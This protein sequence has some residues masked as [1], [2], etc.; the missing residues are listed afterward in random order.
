M[1]PTA[2]KGHQNTRTTTPQLNKTEQTNR[3]PT[4]TVY[5]ASA[6]HKLSSNR[7]MSDWANNG[8]F[9]LSE[10]KTFCYNGCFRVTRVFQPVAVGKQFLVLYKQSPRTEPLLPPR[11]LPH[12]VHLV[13]HSPKN[14]A[15][16]AFVGRASK[17]RLKLRFYYDATKKLGTSG[18][19]EQQLQFEQNSPRILR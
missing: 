19:K 15:L 11:H 7:Y 17:L 14:A 3:V 5:A 1:L 9:D 8:S 6:E 10:N 16:L 18:M 2:S 13:T 12:R 4:I